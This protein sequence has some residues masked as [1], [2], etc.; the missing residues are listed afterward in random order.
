VEDAEN[1]VAEPAVADACAGSLFPEDALLCKA[2]QHAR[3]ARLA[4]A[5]LFLHVA[6][7]G[8]G[9]ANSR[10]TTSSARPEFRR[11]R[12]RY[13]SRRSDNCSARSI[14]LAA[15]T[16]TPSRKNRSHSLIS[17]RSRTYFRQS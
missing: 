13:F 6:D 15:W 16:A 12:D 17:P 9:L 3:G 1:F 2:S 10:S 5:E 4:Y 14:A 7:G 11:R 8:M